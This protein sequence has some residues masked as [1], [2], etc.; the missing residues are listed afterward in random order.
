MNSLLIN[1]HT[2]RKARLFNGIELRNAYVPDPSKMTIRYPISVGLHP[3]FITQ[4]SKQV[5]RERLISLC[6]LPNCKAIGEIGLDNNYP[7]FSVQLALFAWQVAIA[8][9]LRIPVI[10]HQFK[11]HENL[12][13]ILRNFP[14][15]IIL[16]GYN[17]SIEQWKQLNFFNN[18]YISIGYNVLKPSKKLNNCIQAIPANRLFAETDQS[19][20]KIETIYE[21]LALLKSEPIPLIVNQIHENYNRIMPH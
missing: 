1:I 3:W 12:Q 16:H 2:H 4:F 7:N 20:I 6:Q 18:T 17:G 15:P 14:E 10:I 11:S 9:E 19:N 8:K 5:L 21:Q 13:K